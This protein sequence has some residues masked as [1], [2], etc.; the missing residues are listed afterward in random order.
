MKTILTFN[1]F[2][3]HLFESFISHHDELLQLLTPRLLLLLPLIPLLLLLLLLLSPS[4][5]FLSPGPSI[6]IEINLVKLHGNLRIKWADAAKR[7]KKWKLLE[8]FVSWAK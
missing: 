4:L 2:H 5:L 3:S 8:V 1:L 7:E 6:E